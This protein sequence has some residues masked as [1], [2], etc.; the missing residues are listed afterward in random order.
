MHYLE[1][2]ARGQTYELGTHRVTGEEI[3]GFAKRWDP[4]RFHLDACEPV[5][6]ASSQVAGT[7]Q[8]YSCGSTSRLC[9]RIPAALVAPALTSCAGSYPSARVTRCPAGS[10]S[11]RWSPLIVIPDAAP[12][13][14]PSLRATQPR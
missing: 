6:A 14:S 11:R 5:E 7:R 13:T 2:F 8:P 4:Q 9:W 10:P 1:D 3:T 12:F